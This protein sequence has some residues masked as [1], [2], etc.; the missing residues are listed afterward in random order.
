MIKVYKLSPLLLPIPKT[1]A[2][3]LMNDALFD[4]NPL[5][6]WRII[7]SQLCRVLKLAALLVTM[8][9]NLNYH[10][11]IHSHDGEKFPLDS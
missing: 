10:D 1:V 7:Y 6:G 4:C 8:V 9:K 11:L 5:K 2:T 3:N